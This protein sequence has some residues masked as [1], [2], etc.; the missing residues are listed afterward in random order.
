MG[1]TANLLVTNG[2]LRL[3]DIILCGSYC[4]RVRALLDDHGAKLKEAGPSTP[5]KCLGLSGVPDAGAPFEVYANEKAARI[6]AEER[7]AKVKLN[8][9][10]S[11][12]RASLANLFEQIK[13]NERVELK[14]VL[15]ADVQG[16][17][18][19]ID[20]ALKQIKSDKVS[21]TS[22]DVLLASAS[23][24]IVIGFHVSVEEG[25]LRLSKQE[26]IEIRLHS[27]IYELVD[28]VREAMTGLLTPILKEKMTGRAEIK[29]VFTISKGSVIA[30]CVV[31]NGYI[32]PRVK[33]RVKRQNT[34]VY[35]GAISSLRRFQNEAS[36][37]RESQECGIRL[38]NFN[39]FVE[40]DILECFEIERIAQ[41]L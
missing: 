12:R 20:H 36:E 17:L 34:I 4:G 1:P 28:R 25:A 27:I 37:V 41:T 15:K 6:V 30:G 40:G 32:T 14:I 2:T 13:D 18:E 24:A 21:I 16:S 11:P 38:D 39:A 23:D 10:S 31:L 9:V 26:G 8:L 33:V 19:A 22:N 3:G 5:V 7:L 29:Q 35:E